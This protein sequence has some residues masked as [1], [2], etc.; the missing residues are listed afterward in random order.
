M[1]IY[2]NFSCVKKLKPSL[3]LCKCVKLHTPKVSRICVPGIEDWNTGKEEKK[4]PSVSSGLKVCTPIIPW[5][6]YITL[7]M[8]I[9]VYIHTH[10]CICTYAFLCF[11][12]NLC[13]QDELNCKIYGSFSCDMSWDLTCYPLQKILFFPWCWTVKNKLN[14]MI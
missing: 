8:S 13:N 1:P 3:S 6:W 4:P 7:F 9:Y 11:C 12:V 10:K 5:F 14:C 2:W